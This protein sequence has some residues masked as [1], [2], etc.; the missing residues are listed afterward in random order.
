M[1]KMRCTAVLLALGTLLMPSGLHAEDEVEGTRV[2]AIAAVARAKSRASELEALGQSLEVAAKRAK[3]ALEAQRNAPARGRSE[4]A[5]R[6]NARD[7]ADAE[8]ALLLAVARAKLGA[9]QKNDAAEEIAVVSALLEAEEYAAAEKQARRLSELFMHIQA[10]TE[11]DLAELDDA[12]A[13]DKHGRT[14]LHT[15][16]IK[17]DIKA[18]NQALKLGLPVDRADKD[19]FTPLHLAAWFGSEGIA[20][21]LL[22]A[23]A[24]VEISAPQSPLMA[25]PLGASKASECPLSGPTALHLACYAGR[26]AVVELL[27][28]KDADPSVVLGFKDAGAG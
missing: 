23:G 21:R 18:A 14:S 2:S 17:S 19:G 9:A 26:G 1:T 27:L 10:S 13:L 25:D 22:T 11:S 5:R 28:A 12:F 8:L 6:E 24:N 7:V 3:E 20:E 15:A 16:A 4:K